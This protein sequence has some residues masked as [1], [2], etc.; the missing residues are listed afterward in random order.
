MSQKI[1]LNL[2]KFTIFYWNAKNF[3]TA[4]V[5]YVEPAPTIFWS[6]LHL[7]KNRS[8]AFDR[9]STLDDMHSTPICS[10]AQNTG[11]CELAWYSITGSLLLVSAS[12]FS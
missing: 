10:V 11:V 12:T 8:G 6:K 1:L 5:T 9:Y 4:T 2:F 7:F 3:S